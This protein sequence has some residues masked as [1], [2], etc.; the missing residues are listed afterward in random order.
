MLGVIVIGGGIALLKNGVLKKDKKEPSVPIRPQTL[1]PSQSLFKLSV[2][3][4]T[5]VVNTPTI[6][7]V[8]V[9]V[10]S[11]PS[12]L[13]DGDS[14]AGDNIFTAQLTINYPG[15]PGTT[16][17]KATAA[18]TGLLYRSESPHSIFI[19]ASATTAE[20]MLLQ[21]AAALENGSPV[22]DILK[23]FFVDRT[24]N[25]DHITRLPPAG[26]RTLAALFRSAS[27]SKGDNRYRTYIATTTNTTDGNPLQVTFYLTRS[28]SGEWLIDS[29]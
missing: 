9:W 22:A 2:Q 13:R 10:G 28:L 4:D 12:L 15:P 23:T 24:Q 6:I 20:T 29:W 11:A 5:V 14:D 26:R 18:Y 27:F 21:L 19:I 3:P 17:L 25:T 16:A 8:T 7:K 1:P